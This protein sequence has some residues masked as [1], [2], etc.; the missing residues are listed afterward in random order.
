MEPPY[1]EGDN[2]IVRCREV[3]GRVIILDTGLKTSLKK[4]VLEKRNGTEKERKVFNSEF[5][6]WNEILRVL[7]TSGVLKGRNAKKDKNLS[8]GA[9]PAFAGV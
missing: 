6:R 9:F 2:I 5:Y 4:R 1:H 7:A 8:K 3:H